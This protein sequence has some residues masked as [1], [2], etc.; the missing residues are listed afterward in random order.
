MT[1]DEIKELDATLIVKINHSKNNIRRSFVVT[2]EYVKFYKMYV[3]LRPPGAKDRR[4]FYAYRNGKCINQVVGKN[5]FYKVP[6]EVATF[7]G[8]ENP[9]LYTGH[10]FRRSSATLLV[11]SGG[12]LLTLKKHG[13][14]KSST[15]AEGY[16]DESLAQRKEIADRLSANLARCGNSSAEVNPYSQPTTS[17]TVMSMV[18][19]EKST[20]DSQEMS[21]EMSTLAE[22]PNHNKELKFV[23]CTFNNCHFDIRK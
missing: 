10:A 16:I 5:Q 22:T 3:N 19:S 4:L 7:L 1:L 14:W 11:E 13:G 21:Q 8:L 20:D 17:K 15:V 6:E 18:R 9:K 2:E 23:Q 12:D